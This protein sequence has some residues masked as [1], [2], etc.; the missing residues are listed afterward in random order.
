M[1]TGFNKIYDVDNK[2]N[3]KINLKRLG[4]S[5]ESKNKLFLIVKHFKQLKITLNT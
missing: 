2:G 1:K 4:E 3:F 5:E